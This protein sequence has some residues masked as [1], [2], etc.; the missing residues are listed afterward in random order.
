MR[1]QHVVVSL[2]PAQGGPPVVALRIAAAQ[3]SA[4]HDS[5]IVSHGAP[6]KESEIAASLRGIPDIGRVNV[7]TVPP[8]LTWGALVPRA[9]SRR[10]RDIMA[11]SDVVHLHGVWEPLVWHA[12]VLARRLGITYVI[13]PH[14]M[15]DPWSLGQKRLKKRMALLLAYRSMLRQAGCLH[16]LNRD[17]AE[18]IE[19]LKLGTPVQVIPNGVFLEEISPLPAAGSFHANHPEL[20]G[21]PYVLFLGRLHFKKGLDVLAEAFT[22]IAAIEKRLRLVVAGPDGGAK[23]EFEQR[24]RQAR[25]ID[26][27]HVVGSLY[28]TEKFAAMVD[29]RAFCLPSRQEGFSMAITEAMAS[30]CPVVVSEACHFPEV[31]EV[32]AGKIVPLD[33]DAVAAA[34]RDVLFDEGARKRMGEAGRALVMSR[35]TWPAIAEQTLDMYKRAVGAR[36]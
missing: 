4:G 12:S 15:L 2:D 11:G 10:L 27:V 13:T 3:A 31:A 34:L 8:G 17:E 22:K 35:F 6:G 24:I 26:R 18:L 32:G 33:S 7:T 28:G 36:T 25:L 30:G 1:I 20:N 14:G 23:A 9:T 21:E 5:G 16:L 19:P 29:A